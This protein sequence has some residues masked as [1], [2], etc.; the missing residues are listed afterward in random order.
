MRFLVIYDTGSGFS[1][2]A[3]VGV[4]EASNE[5]EAISKARVVFNTTAK[6]NA[7]NLNDC[8]DGWSYYL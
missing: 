1:E 5:M 2:L 8:G 3:N 4:F 7:F 6:L